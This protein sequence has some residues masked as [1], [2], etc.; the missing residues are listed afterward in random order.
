MAKKPAPIRDVNNP[1]DPGYGY[2]A[3]G[4][5]VQARKSTYVENHPIL[6]SKSGIDRI[7]F[8]KEHPRIAK[9]YGVIKNLDVVP[10]KIT[11][12]KPTPPK[13]DLTNPSDPGYGYTAAGRQ[14]QARKDVT[15]QRMA[16]VQRRQAKFYRGLK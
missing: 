9:D 4:R 2:T 3:A 8:L 16:A 15:P 10:K 1:S 11:V 12:P 7:K 5:A 6:Y 13:R 14:A